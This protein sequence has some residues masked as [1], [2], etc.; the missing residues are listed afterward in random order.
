MSS[1]HNLYTESYTEKSFVVRGGDTKNYSE[2]LRE[3]GGKYNANLKGGPGWIFSL[4]HK[5]KVDTALVQWGTEERLTEKKDQPISK[6]EKVKLLAGKALDNSCKTQLDRIEKK[7]D[8][9]LLYIENTPDSPKA[10]RSPDL[11]SGNFHDF[12]AEED[13]VVAPRK[14][15]LR[16]RK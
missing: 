15:L 14:R 5:E 12:L 10:G 8:L 4:R 7:I 6:F 16:R 2:K 3:I 13:E 9:I 1:R 11:R